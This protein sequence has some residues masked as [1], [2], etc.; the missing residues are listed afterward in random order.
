MR[1]TVRRYDVA[2]IAAD[3]R[4]LDVI[5]PTARQMATLFRKPVRLAKFHEARGRGNLSALRISR[6]AR[7]CRPSVVIDVVRV[8][9]FVEQALAAVVARLAQRLKLA[10][11]ERVPVAA[12]RHDVVGDCCRRG[13]AVRKAH[14]AGRM[15]AQLQGAAATPMRRVV[16]RAPGTL[17]DREGIG[18]RKRGTG[19]LHD[20]TPAKPVLWGVH[21]M[22]WR[23]SNR[24]RHARVSRTRYRK[25][26]L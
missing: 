10:E 24:Q 2:L 23:R 14:H 15:L 6:V 9:A 3:R 17:R 21:P 4:R 5:V 16:P 7:I 13:D 18:Q 1:C 8:A 26:L 19:G 25:A 22:V 12:M 20:V 11:D